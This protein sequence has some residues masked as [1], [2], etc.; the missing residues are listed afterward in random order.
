MIFKD[1]ISIDA[2]FQNSINIG[3]DLNDASKV[4]SYIPTS[5]GLNFLNHF[6]SNVLGNDT[7]KSTMIIAPYGKGKSHAMLVLLSLLYKTDYV[8]YGKL[9]DK[10]QRIDTELFKKITLIKNKKY[11]PIVISNTRGTLNQALLHSLQ[12]SLQNA[13]IDKIILDTEYHHV[14]ER[15]NDWK[16]NYKDTYDHFLKRLVEKKINYNNFKK[17]IKG[18]NEKALEQ[19]KEIHK[20]ILS[21]AEFTTQS[22]IEAVEFYQQITEKLIADYG[23][24][25]VYI[26]FDEFSKFLESR[27]EG[28]VTNDMKI[29]QD[30]AEL[31]NSSKKNE[32]FLQLILHK[33]INE[34]LSIDKRIRNSF[35]GIEGR[36]STYYFTSS[37]KNSYDLISN[38]IQK[39]ETYTKVKDQN[40]VINDQIKK[41]LARL[42]IFGSE[43]TADFIE[44]DLVD[45]CYPLH[46][47]TVYLLIK[48]NEK[49]AQNERTLFTFLAKKTNNALS[50]II[51]KDYPYSYIMPYAIYD[52]FENLL[53]EEKDNINIQK[54]AS[55]A[56]SAINS[57]PSKEEVELIKTLAMLLIINEKDVAPS[58]ISVLSA[59]MQIDSAKCKDIVYKLISNN[60]LVQRHGGQIE[61][62]INMDL[63]LETSV[64]DIVIKKYAR[65]NLEKELEKLAESKYFYPRTYN[66]MN[67]ITR[68]FKIT[69]LAENDFLKLNTVEPYFEEEVID[70]LIINIVRDSNNQSEKVLNHTLKLNE[71][72]LVVIYPNEID[73]YNA[74]VKKLLALNTLLEDKEFINNNPLVKTELQLME[75]DY[76]KM[77]EDM[78]EKD[79]A[80]SS[81]KNHI[82]STFNNRELNE[83]KRLISKH[84]ILGNILEKVYDK[85][86]SN[87]NL[88]LI[89]K[90]NVKGTYRKARENVIGQLLNDSINIEKLGTSPEDT[91]INCLLLSNG[92]LTNDSDILGDKLPIVLKEIDDFLS[93]ESGNFADLYSILTKPPYGIRNGIIPLL[94]AHRIS[95]IN[96]GILL[97]YQGQ[98][99]E[100]NAQAI[101]KIAESPKDVTYTIDEINAVKVRYVNQLGELFDC[102]L[103]K[104]IS[105]NYMILST[106]IRAWY[107]SLPKFTRQMI[108]EYKQIDRKNYK[109]LR[110]QLSKANINSSEFI[111]FSIPKI[112]RTNELDI[113]VQR[114]EEMKHTLDSFVFDYQMELKHEINR[115]F[116]FNEETTVNKS[117]NYWLDNN[118]DS[119]NSKILDGYIKDFLNICRSSIHDTEVNLI[120]KIAFCLTSLFVED[121]SDKTKDLFLSELQ[122]IKK[123]EVVEEVTTDNSNKIVLQIDGKTIIKDVNDLLD[124]S[125]E[126]VETFI[127][128]TLEDYGDALT[129]EQKVALFLKLMQKYI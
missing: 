88:E 96:Q 77:I 71:D 78:V 65:I 5:T 35:K 110:K 51:Q 74:P 59:A 22:T 34:S 54:T 89:N 67:S 102:E 20:E 30:L 92:I 104:D 108:G 103:T 114:F 86:P 13:C 76:R 112:M 47:M 53:L 91:I 106:R 84:R 11:L 99:L 129:N 15:I 101:E 4:E 56:I 60:I 43:F 2:H 64:E 81:T 40:K 33:P 93:H 100:L 48:I 118:E 10:I 111:L 3:L 120:N 25:G 87:L 28:T 126:L 70:G 80:L 50:D 107:A 14:I 105:K 49:V 119:F 75:E 95:L 19:F 55:K 57:A 41:D 39:N 128:G 116:G 97:S 113:T 90:T 123:F 69:Y 31:C 83:T 52:Y 94:I 68:F 61:F 82:Y 115:M 26:V 62:K 32:M 85:Y 72:R 7:D 125:L 73:D 12:R 16:N 121:W 66:I 98:E 18:F 122:K 29:I 124:E 37:L 109:L 45:Y 44:D 42:P 23:Y 8:E 117:I 58:N 17:D 46:P 24:D 9:L 6:I 127:E 36:V 38:V 27:D 21:G 1:L 79:Y 63:N